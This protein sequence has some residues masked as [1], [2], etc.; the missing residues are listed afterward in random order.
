MGNVSATLRL[1]CRDITA[2]ELT[3]TLGVEP[4][5]AQTGRD[6]AMFDSDGLKGARDVTFWTYDTGSKV[7]SPD[8]NDHLRHLLRVFLPLK[9][10]IEELRPAPRISFSV[11]WESTIAGVAG[12][13][14]DPQCISGLAALGASLH[15]KVAKIDEIPDA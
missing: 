1:F 6:P 7:S 14:I 12:P 8:L 11:Y 10:R 2:E 5:L 3:A 13:E 15:I 9:S 4:T